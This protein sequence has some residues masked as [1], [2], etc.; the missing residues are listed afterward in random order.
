MPPDAGSYVTRSADPELFE[1]ILRGEYCY[2]LTTRQTGKSSLMARTAR[3][4]A[5]NGIQCAQIGLETSRESGATPNADQFLYGIAWQIIKALKLTVGLD[6]WWRTRERLT[7]TRRFHEFLTDSLLELCG[8]PIVIFVDEIDSTIGL[9]FANDFYATIRACYNERASK[10]DLKRLTFVLLGVATPE[11][12][13]ADPNR[14]PFDVG[15]GIKLTDFAADEAMVLVSAFPESS[16]DREALLDR[17]LHW[18]GGHPYLTQSLCRAIAIRLSE[19]SQRGEEHHVNLITIVDEEVENRFLRPDAARE[20]RNLRF[21]WSRLSQASDLRSALNTYRHVLSGKLIEHKP[22]SPVHDSLVLAGVV[23]VDAEGLFR[24]RNRI[25]EHVFGPE[26]IKRTIPIRDRFGQ[27]WSRRVQRAQTRKRRDDKQSLEVLPTAGMVRRIF[28]C[29]RRHDSGI[30]VGR[31]YDRL[32]GDFGK[33]NIFKDI[34]NIPFG[35]DFVEYLA[36]E[37]KKCN[38]LFVV[39]GPKW[40]DAG[41]T[42]TPRLNEPNDFVRVEI[43]SALRGEIPVVPLLVDGA[44]MPRADHLP[45]EI[46]SLTTRNGVRIRHDP[47]FHVDMTRLLSRLA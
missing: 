41:P 19:Q 36:A 7:S 32:V 1:A 30:I 12:L 14:A 8:G 28:I 5:E 24:S 17:V 18:T 38:T 11:Q 40:L 37:V 9:P 15:Q 44:D 29:Y 45:D 20:E 26:W 27:H 10:A 16:A 6:E 2:V 23:R 31:I 47:D 39:I 4:L 35:V 22:G 33:E 43:S 13:I 3:R 25:Y 42:G 21:V 46:R 34:D